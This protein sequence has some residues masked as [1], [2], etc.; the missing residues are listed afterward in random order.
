MFD[1]VAVQLYKMKIILFI[2][3]FGYNYQYSLAG[4]WCVKSI[5]SVSGSYASTDIMCSGDL[6]FEDNFNDFNFDIWQHESTLGGG[7]VG[8]SH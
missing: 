8:Y 6:I 2:V 1:E 7:G 4:K 3:I 5:T